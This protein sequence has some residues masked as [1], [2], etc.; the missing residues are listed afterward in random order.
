MEAVVCYDGF[1]ET[2]ACRSHHGRR[3]V[4]SDLPDFPPF[5]LR[6]LFKYSNE[7][8]RQGSLYD[9]NQ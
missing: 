6:N 4:G 2:S 9:G 7:G 1:R 3:E 5:I 8:I